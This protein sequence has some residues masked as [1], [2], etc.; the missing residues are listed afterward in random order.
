M[1]HDF[2][3]IGTPLSYRANKYLG[4]AMKKKFIYDDNWGEIVLRRRAWIKFSGYMDY[5]KEFNRVVIANMCCNKIDKY[6]YFDE[7]LS[8]E[9]H[10][11]FEDVYGLVKEYERTKDTE[12]NEKTGETD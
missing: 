6:H 4:K 12:S 2:E 11:M 8:V 7:D 1:Q 3:D 9:W 5:F 10:N